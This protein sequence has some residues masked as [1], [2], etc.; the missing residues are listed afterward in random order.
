MSRDINPFGL[1]MPPELKKEVQDEADKNSRSLN[2]EIVMRLQ[3]SFEDEAP[4]F[5]FEEAMHEALH[6]PKP[7]LN[8]VHVEI[9]EFITALNEVNETMRIFQKIQESSSD[10]SLYDDTLSTLASWRNWYIAV[11]DS[12]LRRNKQKD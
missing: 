6:G 12:H 7:E 5:N 11:I 4:K 1:R 8:P 3:K 2:A 10:E 9:Q